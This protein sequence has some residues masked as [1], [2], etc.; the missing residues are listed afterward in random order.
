MMD[1]IVEKANRPNQV[2]L[3]VLGQI[4]SL[5]LIFEIL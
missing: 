5:M 3:K 4:H 1:Q 2:M